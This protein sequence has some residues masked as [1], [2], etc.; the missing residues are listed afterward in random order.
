MPGFNKS[1]ANNMRTAW[2]LSAGMLSFVV[3]LGFF[4]ARKNGAEVASHVS[5]L[6][7]VATTTVVWLL[8][9]LLAPATDEAMLVRFFA[10]VRPGGPGWTRVRA[11][12]GVGP[13]PDSLPQALLGWM[14]GCAMVYA[15]LFGTG[16]LLYGRMPQF[17]MWLAVFVVSA[18]GVWRVLRGFFRVPKPG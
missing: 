9:T 17:E 11:L 10:L 7:T 14:F 3:A 12:A 15:A 13:S 5:L 6:V 8:A 1:D 16:S 4:I 2:E 18:I